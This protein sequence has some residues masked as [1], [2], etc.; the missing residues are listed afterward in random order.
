MTTL[1]NASF[2]IDGERVGQYE[3]EPVNYLLIQYG[4]LL[5]ENTS[6]TYGSHN[7]TMMAQGA[8]TVNNTGSDNSLIIFDYALYT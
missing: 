4:V 1:F 8:P 3:H 6:L 5:Y 2:L 7:V